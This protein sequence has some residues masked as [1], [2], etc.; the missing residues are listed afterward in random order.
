MK[1]T[2]RRCFHPDRILPVL[3]SLVLAINSV[4]CSG[5]SSSDASKGVDS[6]AALLSASAPVIRIAADDVSPGLSF[7]SWD[8]EGGEKAATNLL[9]AGSAVRVQFLASAA[10]A[11]ASGSPAVANAWQDAKVVDR[12]HG[13]DSNIVFRT[14]EAGP[15]RLEWRIE[16]VNELDRVVTER[17]S[18]IPLE[19]IGS[20]SLTVFDLDAA[21][22]A[23]GSIRLVFPFDPK[24]TSTTVLPA[25]WLDDGTFRLPAVVNAPDWGPMLLAEA[26][27]RPIVGRLEGSRT[28][29]TVDLI[30]ECPALSTA[31]PV[32]LTLTPLLLPPPAGLSDESLPFWLSARRGWLNA[33]QPCARWGEQDKP[34][35]APAGILG[36]NVISDPASVSIWFYAD[37]AFFYP[38]IAPGI[39]VM[40]LVRRTIDYWLDHRMR[41]DAAGRL[42]GEI[43]GYWDYGDFLDAEASPLIAAWD[44]VESTGDLDW[45]RRRVDRL[46]LAADFLARRDVDGDGFVEA[47]QSGDPNALRQPNRSDAWWDAL[48]CGHKDGYTNALIYRAWRSLADLE[49]KLGRADKAAAYTSLADRLK[50]VYAK[51][52]YNPKSGLLAW[53]KGRDG[54]LHDYASPTLNGLAIEYGLVSP[55]Q[56]RAILDRLRIRFA[57]VGFTRFDLGVPPML[58]PVRRSDYLQPNCLGLPTRE[59]GTDTFGYYM[60]GGITAGQVLHFLMAHYVLDDAELAGRA[61]MI[62]RAMLER[63]RRG[64]F[65]NGVRDATF[66]GIDWTTWDGKPSGYE[67]Y[68]ADSFRFLQAVLMREPAFR[69]RL[70]RPLGP[71]PRR[72]LTAEGDRS[73]D[74]LTLPGDFPS[75][76]P[77]FMRVP[78]PADWRSLTKS[79][80]SFD[81]ARKWGPLYD[82]RHA[83]LSRLD[84]TG[85][86]SDLG[87]AFF[88]TETKWPASLP[89]GFDPAKIIDLNRDPGLGL[90][91][92]HRGG[93][94]G[95]GV[96][97][98]IID[99]PILLDH[100]EYGD[101][102]RFYG[103]VNAKGVAA[104]FHGALVTS[105]LAGRTCGIAPEARIYYVGSHNYDLSA[106]MR[107]D[108]GHYARALGQLLEVNARLPREQRIRVLSISAG[109]GPDDPGFKAMNTA[110]RKAASAGIFVVSANVFDT[111]K[112][113]RWFWGAD[114]AGAD[115]PDDPVSYRVLA[116][117]DWISQVGGRG[118]FDKFFTRRLE[119]AGTPEFL[120]IP[121]GSKTVAQPGG[122]NEYGFYRVG[123]WSSICPYIAGLYALACQV[124]PDVTP[125]VFWQAALVTG[126][127]VTVEGAKK[128]YGG[129]RVNPP[130]L[131]DL[132]GSD[133]SKNIKFN[134]ID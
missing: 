43:T 80:R 103:E 78:P 115:D 72:S 119:R 51:V 98:A 42:T 20:L 94:T 75:V 48:N 54:A 102:L 83:D 108:V 77:Y 64:E 70:Y 130:R 7:L 5:K 58:V 116:W 107:P 52:L 61:D 118:G 60:N 117:K 120:V 13:S 45:L 17:G 95:R 111:D 71:R 26:K 57:E 36:N 122:P 79:P 2:S 112:P 105:I 34:F 18:K 12:R 101:R 1:L 106:E 113:E 109:W 55:A 59:D 123:G 56:G 76:K 131:I 73:E 6:R 27:E 3:L 47:T 124:N 87:D 29:K 90:R 31:E 84:L 127:P 133:H 11:A 40:P 89:A 66:E 10:P 41:R 68:L 19:R 8:T 69:A 100:A 37:Q 63:Q 65:Q 93:V 81:N 74:K 46:E 128:T 14:L 35:S 126:D 33:L 24:V 132:M 38:E 25:A 28:G 99:T 97:V 62:L 92:L 86:A 96:T 67:G 39:S 88:D 23:S 125:D 50:A 82:L 114:R 9:R 15:A 53:W 121:E 4:V 129:K 30:L 22:T 32:A 134:K 91:D 110:V 49:T 85:R 16:T 104:N 44:Y 21:P